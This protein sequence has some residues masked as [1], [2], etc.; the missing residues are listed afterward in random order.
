MFSAYGV[1]EDAGYKHR[2][3]LGHFESDLSA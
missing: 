2:L 3:Y 1:V